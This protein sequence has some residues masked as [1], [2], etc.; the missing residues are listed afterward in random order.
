MET[1]IV[2][3]TSAGGEVHYFVEDRIYFGFIPLWWERPHYYGSRY[4][5]QERKYNDHRTL[6][7]AENW[8]L[9]RQERERSLERGRQNRKIVSKEIVK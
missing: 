1:R 8:I 4:F 7:G 6:A 5:S 2:K 9:S 3:E